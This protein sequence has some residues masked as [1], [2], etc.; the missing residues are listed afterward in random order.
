MKITV[1]RLIRKFVAN[2]PIIT[3]CSLD[4]KF[5]SVNKYFNFVDQ[6]NTKTNKN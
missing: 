5:T 1:A 3:K 6:I 4:R 2:D